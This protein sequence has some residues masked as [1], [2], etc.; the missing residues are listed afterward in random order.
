LLCFG[1]HISFRRIISDL[2][3]RNKI[4]IASF[5]SSHVEFKPWQNWN[6]PTMGNPHYR[7][8]ADRLMEAEKELAQK[9]RAKDQTPVPLWGE[10]LTAR[11]NKMDAAAAAAWSRRQCADR[12][13]QR[14]RGESRTARQKK[15]DAEEAAWARGCV[16]GRQSLARAQL[17]QRTTELGE[18]KRGRAVATE[19]DSDE[20]LSMMLTT[21]DEEAEEGE[22]ANHYTPFVK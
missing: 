16:R 3:R 7:T 5:F 8:A 21:F 10:S 1:E 15:K 11:Q 4:T 12:A 20:D 19:H 18:G 17:R 2:F 22:E 6:L 14:S 13:R 9:M